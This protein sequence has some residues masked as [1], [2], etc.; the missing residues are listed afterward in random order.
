MKT[1]FST[2]DVHPRD[3]YD[4]WHEVLCKKVIEHDCTPES[5]QTFRAELQAGALADIGLVL[6]KT[7]PMYCSA[8]LHHVEHANA[9][10]LF[11]VRQLAG[12]VVIEQDGREV[13]LDAGDFTLID[14]RRPVT[15]KHLKGS[16]PLILKVP[17]RQ[18]EARV[19]KTRQ[20]IARSIKPSQAEHRLTSAFLAMLPTHTDKLGPVAEHV[21]RDQALDLVPCRW[22]IRSSCI[23]ASPWSTARSI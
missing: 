17:R 8:T 11:V 14:P 6:Y 12:V 16:R 3:A 19:G 13:C 18:L 9:E 2:A 20:M 15:A 1:V 4:Y 7:T 10:E 22:R 21:V 5:R 23:P